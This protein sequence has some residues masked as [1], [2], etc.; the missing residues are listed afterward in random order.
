MGYKFGEDA[1]ERGDKSGA[2]NRASP[3]ERRGCWLQGIG[4]GLLVVAAAVAAVV[5]VL[6]STTADSSTKLSIIAALD[7]EAKKERKKQVRRTR[8]RC[9]RATTTMRNLT[10]VCEVCRK[11]ITDGGCEKDSTD[12]QK[13]LVVV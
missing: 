8:R 4:H 7:R 13:K 9:D 10:K 1:L 2:A 3:T 11:R 6:H 5:F 12:R